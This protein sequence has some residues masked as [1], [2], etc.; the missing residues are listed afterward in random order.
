MLTALLLATS[1]ALAWDHTGFVWRPEDLPRQWYNTDVV[2]S[3]LPEGYQQTAIEDGFAA[4]HAAECADISDEFAGISDSESRDQT[5]HNTVIYWDD[6]ADEIEAGVLAVTYSVPGSEHVSVNGRTYLAFADADIVFNDNVDWGVKEDIDAG[7]CNNETDVRGVATH[8]IGHSWGMAHS[9][10]QGEECDDPELQSATMF[11]SVAACDTSQSDINQDDIEGITALYGP[12]ATFSTVPN[13]QQSTDRYGGLPL[14]VC[15]EVTSE[16][17]VSSA[18]WHFGDGGTSEELNPCYTYTE[19]GQYTV[20]VDIVLEDPACGS[21]TY[22][23]DELGYVVA[24]EQPTP[25]EGADG[26]FEI[27]HTAG[28]TYQTINHTDLSVYGCVDMVTWQVYKGSSEA[29]ITADN[30]VD[31]NDEVSGGTDLG[32]WAP[33]ITFPSEGSYVVVMNVGGPG[34][35]D[36]G[37]LVVDAVDKAAEGSGGCATVP[38]STAIGGL[39]LAA[40]A[41]TTRRR[42]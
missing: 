31:F 37:F 26:F 33:K 24:C 38:M 41:A 16:S 9:C 1:P 20:S 21:A 42:R 11:W 22:R 27:E 19:K 13:S 28:L 17:P 36:A 40:A 25:E 18:V 23:Y 5:D 32:S 2:E 35:I 30:L 4:W 8:E 12:Y 14:E 3:S 29:D 7:N 10:E 15:F 34:G 39:L 6:P